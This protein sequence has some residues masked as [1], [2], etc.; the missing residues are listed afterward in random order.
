MGW[1]S[2]G[3]SSPLVTWPMAWPSMFSSTAGSRTGTRSSATRPTRLRTRLAGL[4]IC[5]STLSAPGKPPARAPPVRR[6]FWM[7]QFSAASGGV[8]VVSMSLPYRHRP[9]SRRSELR[10]PRPMGLTS[11]WASSVRAR[12]SACVA[13]T[14]ISKPSSPV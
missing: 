11:G 5:A 1:F 10:A 3:L 2:V 9:A 6:T 12:A 4:S 7:A 8:V 13:G 14:E